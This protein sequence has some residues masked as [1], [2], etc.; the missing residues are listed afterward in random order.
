MVMGGVSP[1]PEHADGKK[2]VHSAQLAPVVVYSI[3]EEEGSVQTSKAMARPR[4][5]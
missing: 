5:S 2:A 1:V 4:A 3:D